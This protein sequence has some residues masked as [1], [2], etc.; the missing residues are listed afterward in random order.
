MAHSLSSVSFAARVA[1]PA[2]KKPTRLSKSKH[3]L[4]PRAHAHGEASTAPASAHGHGHG[5]GGGSSDRRPGDKK[6]FVEEMRFVAMK[7]HTREQ[8]PKEGEKRAE[9]KPE[10]QPMRQWE[11]TKEKY[12]AFLVESKVMYEAMEEIVASGESPQYAA[13]VNTGLERTEGLTKDIAWFELTHAMKAPSADGPGLE[14]ATFLK[15]LAKNSPEKFIC[16][17]YNVYFAHSAGGKMIGRKVSEMILDGKE[18]EFYKWA[19]E[20]GLETSLADVK[21]KLN[22]AAESWS[23]EE[24][25]TCLEETSKSFQMSGMLLRLIA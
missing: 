17:F 25:D 8:A 7:L 16:H 4:V 10:Q 1:I 21:D 5:G 13:F 11:P 19:G 24:K 14:Y 6:G 20:G 3:A 9:P 23:R 12:L 18:L 15:A 2:A 22:A